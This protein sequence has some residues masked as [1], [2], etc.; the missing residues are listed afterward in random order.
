MLITPTMLSCPVNALHNLIATVV[1]HIRTTTPKHCILYCFL[2]K[3]VLSHSNAFRPF[4]I[5]VMM[6]EVELSS[7]FRLTPPSAALASD[8]PVPLIAD[9]AKLAVCSTTSVRVAFPLKYA[10]AVSDTALV[11]MFQRGS[12]QSALKSKIEK[13][14]TNSSMLQ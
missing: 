3:I 10:A 8:P 4:G 1:G 11:L 12:N 14:R 2:S 5:L 9:T 7:T 6:A 13:T